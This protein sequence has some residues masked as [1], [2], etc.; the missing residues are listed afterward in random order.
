MAATV[1]SARGDG[2]GGVF[3]IGPALVASASASAS[4]IGG[5]GGSA[6]APGN[7]VSAATPNAH[8][9]MDRV[10]LGKTR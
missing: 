2:G 8:S 7:M 3:S 4:V 1:S 6:H 9:D 5:G 10:L